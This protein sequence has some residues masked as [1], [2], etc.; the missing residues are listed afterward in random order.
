[1]L[2]TISALRRLGATDALSLAEEFARTIGKG[3]PSLKAQWD[4]MRSLALDAGFQLTRSH[5][6]NDKHYMVVV[7]K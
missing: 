1:M 3:S 5:E 4:L 7:R 6:L 2:A